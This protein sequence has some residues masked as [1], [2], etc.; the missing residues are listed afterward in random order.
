MDTQV[1]SGRQAGRQG[2]AGER[3]ANEYG[4][5]HKSLLNQQAIFMTLHISIFISTAALLLFTW[6]CLCKRGDM[7][8]RV[9]ACV[10][11]WVVQCT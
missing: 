7:W 9:C 11:V 5:L 1:D 8:A 2:Y 6:L 10:H 4:I 3:R